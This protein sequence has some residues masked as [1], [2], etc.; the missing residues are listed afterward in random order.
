M[1]AH[2]GIIFNSMHSSIEPPPESLF[3][4]L[5][6]AFIITIRGR[7]ST[8]TCSYVRELA[9][10]RAHRVLP[11]LFALINDRCRV[12]ANNTAENA[13]PRRRYNQPDM[14]DATRPSASRSP[15]NLLS[16]YGFS[17][18]CEFTAMLCLLNVL[19]LPLIQGPQL[20][21]F[22][23]FLRLH[24]YMCSRWHAKCAGVIVIWRMLRRYEKGVSNGFVHWTDI[25][26]LQRFRD[27]RF[28]YLC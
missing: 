3:L 6:S 18:D 22:E 5:E 25:L 2:S 7:V 13:R 21:A 19:S 20:L 1:H 10:E 26:L 12:T 14:N 24:M 11:L 16:L 28:L 27:V 15:F 4:R 23:R 8:C 17:A 9:C